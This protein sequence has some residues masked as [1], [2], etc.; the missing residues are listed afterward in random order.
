M[1]MYVTHRPRF[2]EKIRTTGS[3]RRNLGWQW[4]GAVQSDP[5]D[6]G[7]PEAG[8]NLVYGDNNDGIALHASSLSCYA[9]DRDYGTLPSHPA[10]V[11]PRLCMLTSL[12]KTKKLRAALVKLVS[13]SCRRRGALR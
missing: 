5:D 11:W 2:Q 8:I 4:R 1:T 6:T 10:V 9:R 13:I 7:S 3:I 12:P